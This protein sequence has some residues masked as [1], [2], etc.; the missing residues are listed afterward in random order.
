MFIFYTE[1][2]LT[3]GPIIF[4]PVT[5]ASIVC[6][7]AVVNKFYKTCFCHHWSLLNII[8]KD[9]YITAFH[10]VIKETTESY[11]YTI[12]VDVEAYIVMLLSSFVE[13]PDFLPKPSFA[14]QYLQLARQDPYHAKDLG[15]I[16]L[17]VT[18]VLPDYGTKAG[19]RPDYFISIGQGSYYVASHR[20][21]TNLFTVLCQNFDLLS[22][23]LQSATGKHKT[24]HMVSHLLDF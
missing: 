7:F 21:N 3:L 14:E 23:I 11:G 4:A 2:T 9:E 24:N 10:D 12:P 1:L 17:F 13:R 6:S 5:L 8:M 15:D 18:G 16:C 19:L 20:L 22:N